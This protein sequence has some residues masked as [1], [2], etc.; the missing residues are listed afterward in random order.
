M[1]KY[2]AVAAL[3]APVLLVTL[4]L[5]GA[6]QSVSAPS[7]AG[8]DEGQVQ[9]ITLKNGNFVSGEVLKEKSDSILVDLGYTILD[10][11]RDEIA[12]R[13]P[14]TAGKAP[15]QATPDHDALYVDASASPARERPVKDLAQD[16]CESVAMVSTANGLG[17]GF[18]IDA[19]GHFVT[20]F[21][22]IEG[23]QE[24]SVTLF[25]KAETAL[26]RIK[27]DKVRIVS[28]N[29]YLDLALIGAPLPEGIKVKALPIA[30]S[31]SLQDGQGVFAIG[32]PLGLERTVSEGIISATRRDF[33][34]Q[35]FLQTTAPVNPGNSGGPLF[36]LRGQVVGVINMK[37]GFFTEGLSFAIPVDTLKFFLR[38]RDVFAFD[39]DNPNSGFHYLSPPRKAGAASGTSPRAVAK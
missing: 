11:P 15:A 32:N 20:N 34:G 35:I 31:E 22:V 16:L 33:E 2:R 27:I 18:A 36:N 24:I 5:T 26:D 19:A 17:S 9:I 10:I 37:A 39:K 28:V 30:A 21:H 8:P 38:N 1:Q 6:A 7:A 13:A 14:R 4:A 12:K 25:R 3:S 23:E 29:P